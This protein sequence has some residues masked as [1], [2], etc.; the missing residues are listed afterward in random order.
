[1]FPGTGYIGLIMEAAMQIAEGRPVQ[2]IDLFNL[3]IRKAITIHESTGTELLI[4]LTKVSPLDPATNEM[5]ADFTVF[6][7]ISKNSSQLAL[8][9]CGNVRIT[10]GSDWSSRFS[11]RSPPVAKMNAV[12]VDQFYQVMRDDFGFV[13]RTKVTLSNPIAPEI[14]I[15]FRATK[16]RSEALQAYRADGV[17]P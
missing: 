15:H 14:N 10:L 9:C 4:S 13:C 8:N 5:T 11:A 6:S 2:S 1:M 16:A 7:T 3:E 12:D 17:I